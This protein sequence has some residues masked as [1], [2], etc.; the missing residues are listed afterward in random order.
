MKPVP[1]Q[2]EYEKLLHS[3]MLWELFPEVDGTYESFCKAWENRY[4]KEETE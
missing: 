2:N 3:G 1:T 4:N